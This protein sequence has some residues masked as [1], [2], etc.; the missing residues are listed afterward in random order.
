MDNLRDKI[1][2]D[3]EYERQYQDEK[4]GGPAHD[5]CHTLGSF[6]LY[7]MKQL[8]R[9]CDIDDYANYNQIFYNQMIKVAALACAAA[10]SCLRRTGKCDE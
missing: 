2:T 4:W 1:L 3:I 6:V 5:D 8:G 7:M 9:S 10:E